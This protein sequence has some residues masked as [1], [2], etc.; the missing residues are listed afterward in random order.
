[1]KISQ[2]RTSN[3]LKRISKM[4]FILVL[5]LQVKKFYWL[6]FVKSV[7]VV[8]IWATVDGQCFIDALLVH[9]FLSFPSTYSQKV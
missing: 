3:W 5:A 8:V 1:M 6:I 7:R 2:L 9:E 4:R